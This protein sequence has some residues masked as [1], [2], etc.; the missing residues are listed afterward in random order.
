MTE[1]VIYKLTNNPWKKVFPKLLEGVVSKGNKVHVLCA[2]EKI[3]E[4]DDVLWTYEQLAFLP[5]GTSE[6]SHVENQPIILS[7]K[8]QA[9]NGAKILAITNDNIPENYKEYDKILFV[10]DASQHQSIPNVVKQL[11]EYGIKKSYFIQNAQGAWD[12]AEN[13]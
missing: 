9:L 7:S 5:H 8:P 12:K 11:E 4:I 10:F 3:K 13:L 6:D 1:A 2:A